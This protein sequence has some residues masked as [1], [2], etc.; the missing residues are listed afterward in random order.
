MLPQCVMN[1]IRA[2]SFSRFH[3]NETRCF[4]TPTCLDHQL[5]KMLEE[6]RS[7]I[8]STPTARCKLKPHFAHLSKMEH[9]E[10]D[11]FLTTVAITDITCFSCYTELSRL[12]ASLILKEHP[13]THI[14]HTRK[15]IL[16]IIFNVIFITFLRQPL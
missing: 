4:A 8:R 11:S 7:P 1:V 6:M 14:F 2:V 3:K 15:C 13:G 9:I 5:C 16:K 10:S 12:F